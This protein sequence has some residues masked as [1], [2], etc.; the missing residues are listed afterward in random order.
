MG[1]EEEGFGMSM[2]SSIVYVVSDSVG[3][4]AEFVVRAAASQY[5]Y[6]RFEIRKISYVNDE[7]TIREV[8][9]KARE[10][11]GMIAYT[12]IMPN[13]RD[14]LQ[15]E[16]QV[17]D[18]R[19]VDIMGPMMAAL[20]DTFHMQPKLRPGLI[21][22]LDDDYFSRVDA[23]EFAVSADDG[24]DPHALIRADVVLVGVSRTSKTP[25]S[26]YL[27]HKGLRVANV[28]LVPEIRPPEELFALHKEKVVGLTINPD[29]LSSIRHERIRSLGLRDEARYASDERIRQELSYAETIMQKLACRVIDVSR[30]AVEETANLILDYVAHRNV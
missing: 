15:Q 19:I 29:D 11:K 13:L 5:D 28:P 20:E 12:L 25:L 27:A 22:Q 30:R 3:E 24:K 26:M 6:V 7:A 16:A 9:A 23:I 14:V 2:N 8:V 18:V 1:F 10:T 17:A 21:H 4:T